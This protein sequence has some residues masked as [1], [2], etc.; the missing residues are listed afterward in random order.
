L[1]PSISCGDNVLWIGFPDEWLGLVGVVLFDEAVDGSLEID[2]GME[3]AVFEP[4]PGQ[5][6]EEA[7]DGIEP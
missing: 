1:E 7:F 5:F 3:D 6:G 2:D 4:P